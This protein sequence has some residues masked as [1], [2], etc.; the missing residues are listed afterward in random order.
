M[1]PRLPINLLPLTRLPLSAVDMHG[2]HS[3]ARSHRSNPSHDWL[4]PAAVAHAD[5]T[6]AEQLLPPA[7]AATPQQ[8]KL[9]V[10][11]MASPAA[12][13]N[14]P[15]SPAVVRS[16]ARRA[17]EERCSVPVPAAA[18][19]QAIEQA[20]VHAAGP[21]AGEADTSPARRLSLA[22]ELAAAAPGA[23][24]EDETAPRR[25][26]CISVPGQQAAEA[27]DAGAAPS[28]T[29]ERQQL[30][31]AT[32]AAS[33]T[34]RAS[35]A[36]ATPYAA[37]EYDGDDVVMADVGE[38]WSSGVLL[39]VV[40]DDWCTA[41]LPRRL[42]NT[43]SLQ[44]RREGWR[45]AGPPG[46]RPTP[47]PLLHPPP[48]PLFPTRLHALPHHRAPPAPR[49]QPLPGGGPGLSAASAVRALCGARTRCARRVTSSSAA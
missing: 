6:A 1:G 4:H 33:P 32:A 18:V 2:T 28:G 44:R 46:S 25:T 42:G 11:R 9:S 22:E 40:A 3:P 8:P 19:A 5:G 23:E 24:Q 47:K 48:P 16:A 39:A 43:E 17:A 41:Q 36:P 31:P 26:S 10:A 35:P 27:A 45:G 7:S 20:A 37:T 21:G 30:A 34:V 13:A 29:P 49:R 12:P 38:L 14:T 15:A